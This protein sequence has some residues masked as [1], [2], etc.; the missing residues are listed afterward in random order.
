MRAYLAVLS[1]RFR[2]LLQYRAAAVA[3][4]ACQIVF[5]LIMVMAYR[6]F[7]RYAGGAAQ[8]MSL[9]QVI[10][11]VWLG[12]ATI[13]LLIQSGDG[14]VQAM[15]RSGT[16]AYEMLRPVDLYTFWYSRALAGLVAPVFLRAVPMLILAKLML[17]LA[18]PVSVL[19][20]L[21]W[22]AS[23]GLAFLL[24]AAISAILTVT[25]IWTISG[26]GVNR[27]LGTLMW[28]LSG[29]VV[30]LPLLPDWS[31][32]VISI[33]PFRGMLD[34]PNRIY[35]GDIPV[36]HALPAIAHQVA[37]TIGLVLVGRALLARAARRL[38]IQGG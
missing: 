9:N 23:V 19:A 37:W 38:V 6:A 10:T 30:P 29:I 26:A 4:L 17:G 12:Q 27:L 33:L 18:W 2:M 5:G 35:T 28:L 11:Y 20:G 14:D 25:L 13:R 7:Y 31:Q 22:I 15:I 36:C 1:A 34:T 32:P 21:T 3:G 24:G 8:P 16:V